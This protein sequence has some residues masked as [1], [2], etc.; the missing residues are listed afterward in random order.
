MENKYY[1]TILALITLL[2]YIMFC[3]DAM[4]EYFTEPEPVGKC[5]NLYSKSKLKSSGI[6]VSSAPGQRSQLSCPPIICQYSTSLNKCTSNQRVKEYCLK[7]QY[8][9]NATNKNLCQKIGY[10]WENG[11][12]NP[13]NKRKE[14]QC[15]T[16]TLCKWDSEDNLCKPKDGSTTYDAED[17]DSVDDYCQHLK[18]LSPDVNSMTCVNAGANYDYNDLMSKCLNV[19]VNPD[20]VYD[21]C[22]G[23]KSQNNCLDD[24]QDHTNCVWLPTL[25]TISTADDI[26]GLRT[27]ELETI[28]KESERVRD[29][30]NGYI[31]T[32]KPYQD[33]MD[34]EQ[35]AKLIIDIVDRDNKDRY[36]FNKGIKDYQAEYSL[37][38]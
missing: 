5:M 10:V 21:E 19:N 26:K 28:E 14:E 1:I 18:G 9:E 23:N 15:P 34:K 25:P 22:W 2:T 27:T 12:C 24:G 16:D 7:E 20:N 17:Y 36:N 13:T 35:A 32:V 30:I 31:R 8:I 6:K 33:K 4:K 38:L 11:E 29:E 37:S 3:R